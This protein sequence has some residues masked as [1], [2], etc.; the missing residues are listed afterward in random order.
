MLLLHGLGGG[1]ERDMLRISFWIIL[2]L[3]SVGLCGLDEDKVRCAIGSDIIQSV[4]SLNASW[5]LCFKEEKGKNMQV[6][7][8][9]LLF[10]R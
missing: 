8:C 7:V 2:F 9:V 4:P 1:R 6:A 3:R 10:L 5:L